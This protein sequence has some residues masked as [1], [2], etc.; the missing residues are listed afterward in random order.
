M[1]PGGDTS[2]AVMRPG[3]GSSQVMRPGGSSTPV[4]MP[5]GNDE[6]DS[7]VVMKPGSSTVSNTMRPGDSGIGGEVA[8]T[9]AMR[10]GENAS[11]PNLPTTMNQPNTSMEYELSKSEPSFTKDHPVAPVNLPH[12]NKIEVPR[13]NSV[14]KS[15]DSYVAEMLRK[16]FEQEQQ[17]KRVGDIDDFSDDEGINDFDDAIHLG[18]MPTNM[19]SGTPAPHRPLVGGFAAAAY[20]AARAYHFQQQGSQMRKTQSARTNK[21]PPSI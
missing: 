20:E 15:G 10:P 5:G 19:G 12:D 21:P 13:S 14:L 18:Q 7:P 8:G 11:T 6:G 17:A 4:I 9:P 2:T 1:R 3:S 16:R